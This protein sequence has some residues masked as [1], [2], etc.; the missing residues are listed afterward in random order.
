[1]KNTYVLMKIDE[2]TLDEEILE[3]IE[4][5]NKLFTSLKNKAELYASQYK[6]ETIRVCKEGENG[7]L[8]TICSVT[9]SNN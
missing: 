4:I 5:E 1:M 8:Q 7:E 6:E 2:Q 3:T 9:F